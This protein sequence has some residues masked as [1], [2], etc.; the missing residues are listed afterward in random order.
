MD[1]YLYN[2][3]SRAKEKFEPLTP[4][5]VGLYTCGPTVYNFAHIGNL[6]TFLFE[7][8]LTRALRFN[9]YDVQWET[10]GEEGLRALQE[11]VVPPDLILLDLLLPDISGEE[12]YAGMDAHPDWRAIP[13]IVMSGLSTGAAR[14]STLSRVVYI[15]KPFEPAHLLALVAHECQQ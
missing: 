3:L 1:L 13:V 5:R 12:V 10:S 14:A 15:Q 6:R 2:T 4:G 7:D 8:L 9:G 11:A